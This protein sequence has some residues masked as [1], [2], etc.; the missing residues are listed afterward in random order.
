MKPFDFINRA[1]A[2]YIDRLHE[3]YL[4]DPASVEPHWQ[5][6]F[7]GF[8]AAGGRAGMAS[9]AFAATMSSAVSPRYQTVRE[10]EKPS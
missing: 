9:A 10:G 7:A 1:N 3:Q 6:F 8:E 5:A 2:D 4:K